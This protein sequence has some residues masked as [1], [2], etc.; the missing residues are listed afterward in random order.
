[1]AYTPEL[2]AEKKRIE[3]HVKI[4]SEALYLT[5]AECM[6]NGPT[7]ED[8]IAAVRKTFI[9]HGKKEYE[10]PAKI[11]VHPHDDVFYHAM[12]AYVPGQMAMGCKWIECYPRNPKDWG[13]LRPLPFWCQRAHH[14]ISH[15]HNGRRMGHRNAH[16][17]LPQSLRKPAPMRNLRY[18]RL[19]R[20]GQGTSAS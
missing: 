13:L 12:P 10:M 20:W 7:V 16:P 11:G 4:G 3:Q 1:M 5:K 15:G 19:R 17:P 18:V 14:R 6:E 8:T 2:L 9:A